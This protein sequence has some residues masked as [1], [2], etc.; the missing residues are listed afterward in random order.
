MKKILLLALFSSLIA[1]EEKDLTDDNPAP[2]DKNTLVAT[3]FI[4]G[5]KGIHSDTALSND[6]GYSFF[7][8]D[9]QVVVNEFYFVEEGDTVADRTEPFIVS[10][11]ETDQQLLKLPPRGYSGYYG[12]QFGL[13]SIES[14]FASPLLLP[15]GNEL[16]NSN[17]YRKTADGIDQFIIKGRLLDPDNP[18]DTIGTIPFQY[19]LGTYATTRT[20]A[21]LNQNFALARNSNVKFVLQINLEPVF[22]MLD[23]K[24]FPKVTSDPTVP[25][26][27]ALAISMAENLEIDLF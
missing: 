23:I 12:L 25:A 6:L 5:E 17:V 26:D 21:S 11:K 2:E 1:C 3:S 22:E 24:K 10:L 19:R 7:I 16:R 9:I 8:T 20:E 15:E 18:L 4:Y 27:I 13:D 14:F